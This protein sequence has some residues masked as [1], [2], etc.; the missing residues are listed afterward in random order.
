MHQAGDTTETVQKEKN[1]NVHKRHKY[2]QSQHAIVSI[3]QQFEHARCETNC[4]E[5]G[6]THFPNSWYTVRIEPFSRSETDE[7]GGKIQK[8]RE[9]RKETKATYWNSIVFDESVS[10]LLSIGQ[11]WTILCVTCPIIVHTQCITTQLACGCD[12]SL[13]PSDHRAPLCSSTALHL[14]DYTRF[15]HVVGVISFTRMLLIGH[16]STLE[17]PTIKNKRPK[18]KFP[19]DTFKWN[20]KS[21]WYNRIQQ[22]FT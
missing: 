11:K 9:E 2:R 20:R 8:K 6:Q 10:S 21:L 17:L 14:P 15:R 1:K 5:S 7:Y 18:I 19:S 13:A 16:L 3:W 12:A 4:R 22:T